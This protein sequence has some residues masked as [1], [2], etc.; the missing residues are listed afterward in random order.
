M[1]LISGA[2]IP[3]E[4]LVPNVY[5]GIDESQAGSVSAVKRALV[6]GIMRGDGSAEYG[7]VVRVRSVAEARILFGEGSSAAN[8]AIEILKRCRLECWVLPELEPGTGVAAEWLLPVS[9][10]ASS[11]GGASLSINGKAIEIAVK[12]GDD[13]EL[14]KLKLVA[15]VNSLRDLPVEASVDAGGV[16]LK[17]Y[18]KGSHTELS[19]QLGTLAGGL[20]M[21][22]VA[23]Q[24]AGLGVLDMGLVLEQ[25][26]GTQYHY[27]ASDLFDEAAQRVWAEELNKR[28]GPLGAN[29]GR[30]FA[31][32]SGTQPQ[33]IEAAEKINCPHIV[34]LPKGMSAEDSATWSS[35]WAAELGKV[36]AEDPASNTLELPLPGL[37]AAIDYT[38]SEREAMLL[39]GIASYSRD[40]SGAVYVERVVT[41]FKRTAEGDRTTAY[42]DVQV[43][44]TMSAI[45]A[46]QRMEARK[47]FKKWK[48][49]SADESFGPGAKVMSPDVW[50]SFLVSFYQNELMQKR[51]MVEDLQGYKDSIA[52]EVVS[53]TRLEWLDSPRP[54]G[55]FLVA[56]GISSFQ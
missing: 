43:V 42:L 3:K 19:L 44:E 21:G 33:M 4:L 37:Q 49:A 41:S 7:K 29:D 56:A 51:V 13:A 10:T 34:L 36:L 30:L 54:I 24:V 12:A 28:Y 31:A 9:G 46:M 14:V 11:A 35:V 18:C 38:F 17:A 8:M 16:L 1:S 48:L 5:H 47:R 52:V 27:I 25:L 40:A 32:L 53:K 2:E 20:V 26:D 45:R 15:A 23:V 22:A 6:V 39:A 50:R 55:Q